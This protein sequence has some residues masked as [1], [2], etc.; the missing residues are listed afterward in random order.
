MLHSVSCFAKLLNLLF[1][2]SD[3]DQSENS[4]YLSSPIR[5]I[6]AYTEHNEILNFAGQL[7]KNQ[8]ETMEHVAFCFMFWTSILSWDSVVLLKLNSPTL[9]G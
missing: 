2:C 6:K 4:F 9:L 8:L 5:I 3:S 1:L 7:E